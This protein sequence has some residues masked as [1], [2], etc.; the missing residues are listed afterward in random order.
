MK[1]RKEWAHAEKKN[2]SACQK[3]QKSVTSI[4]VAVTSHCDS[5]F[6]HSNISFHENKQKDVD[7]SF[8][9]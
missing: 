1:I 6:K 3:P 2:Y 8:A 9:W 5:H 4:P 7:L